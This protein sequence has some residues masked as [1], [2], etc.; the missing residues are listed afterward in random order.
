MFPDSKEGCGKVAISF[1]IGCPRKH[2][3]A[4]RF[5]NHCR[6]VY[7]GK[8][9]MNYLTDKVCATSPRKH[10]LANRFGNHSRKNCRWEAFYEPPAPSWVAPSG[11]VVIAFAFQL[12]ECEFGPRLG[13]VC[14]FVSIYNKIVQ[15][16]S[17]KI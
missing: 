7:V 4:N 8:L 11:I 5:R 2:F 10:L 17:T 1:S 12:Y 6:K 15:V 13:G 9:F 16:S 14:L 3:R